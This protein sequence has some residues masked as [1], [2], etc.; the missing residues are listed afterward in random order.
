M[1]A[2]LAQHIDWHALQ[3]AAYLAGVSIT[4]FSRQRFIP[5]S[6]LIY[7]V[8]EDQRLYVKIR[9]T[10]C[11]G[12]REFTPYTVCPYCDKTGTEYIEANIKSIATYC[13]E[14]LTPTEFKKLKDLLDS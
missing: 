13:K 12:S 10:F 2:A 14:S 8:G 6:K 5:P 7:Y 9:C 1:N 11:R 4:K 3:I